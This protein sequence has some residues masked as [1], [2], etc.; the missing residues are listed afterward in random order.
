MT[1]EQQLELECIELNARLA[2]M[3]AKCAQGQAQIM[4]INLKE[5]RAEFEA[6]N[7][8][9][10]TKPEEAPKQPPGAED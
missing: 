6:A 9:Q 5:R 7:H 2:E 10:K 4:R 1:R 8:A 3:T